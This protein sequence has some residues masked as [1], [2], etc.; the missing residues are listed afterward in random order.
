MG[1]LPNER[2]NQARPFYHI[3]VDYCGPFYIKEKKLWNRGKVKVS[4]A[5]FIC[6]AVKAVHLEVVSDLT[7]DGFIAS[8]KRFIARR[9]KCR[10]IHSDNETN[11]VGAN[12]QLRELYRQVQ[13]E[14]HHQKVQRYLTDEGIDWK[15]IPARS[16]NFGGLWEAAVKS[17][18]HH[19]TRIV[20][21]TLLTFEELNT[22]VIEIEAILNS[23]PI[24]S[25]SSD[26]NDP[27]A[28]TP[29][30]FLI[31]DSLTSIPVWNWT[32][33][34][35]NRLSSWETVQK[36]KQTFW[37]RWHKDYINGL[38]IRHKWTKRSHDIKENTI[39]VIKDDNLR[40]L[41]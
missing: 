7:T 4:V 1:E 9:G 36:L 31:G 37:T 19:M 13:S 2:V 27:I 25:S 12:N 34:P 23:R 32:D 30:H 21:D 40:P 20:G 28:I 15:F 14:E 17:Y 6:L 24:I 11:F 29:G 3:G 10:S 22:Y 16:P 18:K 33:I 26:P 8:L 41:R 5:V 39:V 38:N 35:S